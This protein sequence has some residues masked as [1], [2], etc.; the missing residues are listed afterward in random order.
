M[1]LAEVQKEHFEYM[2]RKHQ[3]LS[4]DFLRETKKL[5]KDCIDSEDEEL[6]VYIW[7]NFEE[8]FLDACD[9]IEEKKKVD[10]PL[11]YSNVVGKA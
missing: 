1:E 8:L 6:M 10:L 3:K 11:F 2:K 9:R 5:L 7:T 4:L